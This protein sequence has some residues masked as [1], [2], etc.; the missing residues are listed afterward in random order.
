MGAGELAGAVCR[1]AQMGWLVAVRP[2]VRPVVADPVAAAA[3]VVGV[4]A[5]ARPPGRVS[6]GTIRI[7]ARATST[8]AAIPGCDRPRAA[9]CGQRRC[10][11]V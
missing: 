10:V 11:V 3:A 8:P 9:V 7:D 4:A 2:V 5:A 1:P 6:V